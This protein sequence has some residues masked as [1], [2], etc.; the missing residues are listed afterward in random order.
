MT[1][2]DSGKLVSSEQQTRPALCDLTNLPAKRGISSILGDLIN[3]SGK[4]IV[5]HE[6]SREKFSKRLCLVVDDLVKENASPVGTTNEG[7]SSN[8][9][10]NSCGGSDDDKGESEEYH[11]AVMEFSG[12]DG[13]A[14]KES[15]SLQIYFEPG[16]RDGARELNESA[17]ACQTDVTGEGLALSV[18]TGNAERQNPGEDLPNCRNLRSFEM[19]RCSNV[20]RKEHVDQN[21]GDDLLKSCSCSF[22]LKAAYIWSDLHYQD[23]KGRLSALKKSQKKASNLIQRNGKEWPTDFHAAV[24]SS[25]SGKQESKLMGQWRSLFL[26]MGEILGH[27]SNHLQKSFETM[28]KYRE[29]CKMDLERAMK[30]PH[31]TPSK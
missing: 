23:T 3:E 2:E 6:G 8:Y 11:D 26:S 10:K 24:N 15:R 7:S 4:S 25:S 16:D 22:C 28:S 9:K 14:S 21:M 18:F 13:N 12:G 1:E 31:T 29:D 30:T 27:E 20:K 19:S 17:D 5:A